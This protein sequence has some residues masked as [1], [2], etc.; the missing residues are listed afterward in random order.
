MT[1]RVRYLLI[2]FTLVLAGCSGGLAQNTRQALSV[3]VPHDVDFA[4]LRYYALRARSAYDEPDK[5]RATY[6][7]VT[8]VRTVPAVD[9]RYFIETD[10]AARVQTLSVR[11]TAENENV[12]QDIAITLEYD[13]ILGVW[14]HRGFREDALAVWTDAKP[15]L[16]KDYELRVTGHSLGAA[17]ALL[18]GGYANKED[19]NIV[20]V[21]NFGQPKVTSSDLL[22]ENLSVL[23]RVVD[24]NDVVPMLPPPGFVPKYRHEGSEVILRPGAQYVFLDAHNADRVSIAEFWRE[25]A[26]FSVE[27]HKMDRYI[28]NIDYKLENGFRQVPYFGFGG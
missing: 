25:F 3:V 20:R 12:W 19:Y 4:E 1:G 15:H 17:I 13:S 18:I 7:D 10:E 23:T 6:D 21:V 27:E 2:L 24:D 16:Q 11:G 22:P 28:A 5:I 8:R 14:L 9:V 26:A